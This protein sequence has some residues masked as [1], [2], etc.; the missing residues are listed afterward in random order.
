MGGNHTF[1]YIGTNLSHLKKLE[2]AFKN[3]A[4]DIIHMNIP[5]TREGIEVLFNQGELDDYAVLFIEGGYH[6]VAKEH[7]KPNY[8]NT[9]IMVDGGTF[10]AVDHGLGII[11]SN[12]DP[13]ELILSVNENILTYKK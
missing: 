3:S 4:T 8:S 13:K 10:N 12:Q 6:K 1:G 9:I 7:L 2:D 11:N 5:L